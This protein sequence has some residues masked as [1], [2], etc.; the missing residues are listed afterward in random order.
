LTFFQKYYQGLCLLFVVLLGLSLG[1]LAATGLGI[2]LSPATALPQTKAEP[3]AAPAR[4][5][6]LSTFEV[7]LHRDIFDSA[8]HNNTA[9]LTP[10]QSQKTTTPVTTAPRANLTLFGTVVA[11]PDS[12][13]V[14]GANR[15]IDT[16]RLGDE[17]PGGGHL[18]AVERVQV[19]IKNDDGSTETLTLF[20]KNKSKGKSSAQHTMAPR[21]SRGTANAGITGQGIRSIGKNRWVIPHGVADSARGNL[22]ELL[23][24]ARMVPRIVNGQTDGF[25]VEMVRPHTFISMLG[26]RRG[27][28]VRQVNGVNLNS[29]EQALQIFQQLREARHITIGLE[30]NGKPQSF[31]YEIN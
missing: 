14:I 31:E 27:D 16:Y 3:T 5:P 22:N 7:V 30:R 8:A 15:K 17:V 24:Q 13:A 10:V 26:L 20:E 9:F 12:L 21:T 2:Y 23:S 11:G 1:H 19:S 25:M 18:A 6:P 29:P 4:I 28:I